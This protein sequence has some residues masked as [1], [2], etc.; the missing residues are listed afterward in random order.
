MNKPVSKHQIVRQCLLMVAI[1]FSTGMAVHAQ[2]RGSLVRIAEIEVHPEH[3]EAY[4]AIL[5]EE[6]EASV[7]LEEG[8]VAIFP[9]FQRENP[10]QV[11]ILEIYRDERAYRAHLE[12]A[13][14]LKY[15]TGTLHMVKSL[16]LVDM[17]APDMKTAMRI[18]AKFD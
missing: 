3:L 6:A 9:M 4:T 7:R 14:F 18:F 11:R 16:K 13:H 17:D 1:L 15:K 12:T 8:V 2:P 5:T 10:A